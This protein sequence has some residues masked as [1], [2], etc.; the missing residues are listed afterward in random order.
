MSE[1][2]NEQATT[3]KPKEYDQKIEELQTQKRE[4]YLQQERNK[5]SNHALHP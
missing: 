2:E 3:I 1:Q 5:L 4:A